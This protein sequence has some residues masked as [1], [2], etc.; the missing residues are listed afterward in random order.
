MS[1]SHIYKEQDIIAKIIHH[2]INIISIEAKLFAIR[3]DINHA[4]QIQDITHIIIITDAIPATKHIFNMSIHSYQL[5][6]I[7]ISKDLREFFKKNSTNS[8]L[9]WDYLSSNK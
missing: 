3:C 1:V 7:T 5:H 9:F 8:I 2:T 4:T 6:S